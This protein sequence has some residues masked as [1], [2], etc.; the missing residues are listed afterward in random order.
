MKHLAGPLLLLVL[1]GTLLA[2]SKNAQPKPSVFP[3]QITHVVVISQENRTPDNLFHFITPQ[4]PIPSG[5]T[6]LQACTPDP[7]DQ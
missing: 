3:S 5:A 6:G 4:C 1:S 2:Q 7:G